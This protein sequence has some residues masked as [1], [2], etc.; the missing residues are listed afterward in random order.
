M[1]QSMGAL[2][3]H[4]FSIRDQLCNKVGCLVR[5]G[6]DLRTDLTVWDY[7]HLTTAGAKFVIN[8]GL[9]ETIL[10]ILRAEGK[11]GD[12]QSKSVLRQENE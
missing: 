12:P 3:V 11:S 9:G 10:K 4:L 1:D 8:H 7:G 2:P 5:L 6:P